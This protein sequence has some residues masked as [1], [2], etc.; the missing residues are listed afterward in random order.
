M[1]TDTLTCRHNLVHDSIACV[2]R[3]V[4][5]HHHHPAAG[6]DDDTGRRSSFVSL[7]GQEILAQQGVHL[8]KVPTI[9]PI[10]DEDWFVKEIT[11]LCRVVF[12]ATGD[13]VC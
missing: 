2:R 12:S 1:V 11:N 8:V 10:L 6:G 4:I 9:L 13:D 5:D 7:T 3:E